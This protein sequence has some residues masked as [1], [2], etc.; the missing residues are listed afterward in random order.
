MVKQNEMMDKPVIM[1]KVRDYLR[2]Q[3]RQLTGPLKELQ[4]FA[5]KNRVPVIPHET[6]VFLD[7][8]LNLVPMTE[9]LEIG[10]AIGFSTILIAERLTTD[11]HITTID[12]N[13]KM[14]VHARKNFKAFGLEDKISLIE[15]DAAEVLQALTGPYDFVFMDSA[16]AK[17]YDFF[18]D[19]MTILKTNGILVVDD[20]LQ[21]GTIVDD[22]EDIPRRVRTIHKKLNKFLDYVLTH[23]ALK[24]SILP[25]GDGLLVIT[26]LRDFDFKADMQDN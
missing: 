16:K 12:R 5:S 9:A 14:T 4:D 19:V 10:T 13:P 17:Y 6:V 11:G 21:G 8:L 22:I 1:P 23:E 20:V 18:P 26:K 15:E 7:W 3:Q 25:L 24:A 2:T